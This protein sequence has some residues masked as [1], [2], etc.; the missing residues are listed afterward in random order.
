ML[1]AVPLTHKLKA[2]LLAVAVVN[3]FGFITHSRYLPDR[4]DLN[5]SFP[6]S[7]R[8]SLA[9]QLADLFVTQV[10]QRADVGM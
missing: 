8:S 4:R 10:V 2:T 5:R 3:A 9:A 7:V 6:G 1:L